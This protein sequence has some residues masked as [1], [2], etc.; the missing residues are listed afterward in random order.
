[1]MMW[2]VRTGIVERNPYVFAD[3]TWGLTYVLHGL[4]GVG[5]VGLVIAH[6]YFAL[7][8]E[9]LWI[10]KAMIFGTISRRELPRVPRSRSLGGRGQRQV[11]IVA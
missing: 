11:V 4:T 8:P 3:T 1:M 6:I 5:F 7:R 9:K 2:R 10:T